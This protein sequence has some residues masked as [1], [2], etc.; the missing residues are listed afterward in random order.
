MANWA[1]VPVT[2][3]GG[4][5]YF[6]VDG[7][8]AA[9]QIAGLNKTLLVGQQLAAGTA[10]AKT[11]TYLA[12]ADAAATAYGAG[13]DLHRMAVAFRKNYPT[14]QLYGLGIADAAGTQKTTTIT[15]T[16]TNSAAGTLY[17]CIGGE[18]LEISIPITQTPTQQTALMKA[19]INAAFGLSM[20]AE[21]DAE[22]LT[23]TARHKGTSGNGIPVVLNRLGSAGGQTSPAGTTYVIAAGVSGATDPDASEC[24]AVMTGRWDYV[25]TSLSSATNLGK[26]K[27]HF[28][29]SW[30]PGVKRFGH[31]FAGLQDDA[32]TLAAFGIARND[33]HLCI[34]GMED[35]PTSDF[36]LGASLCGAVAQSADADRSRP[37]C[38]LELVDVK[39]PPLASLWSATEIETLLWGGIA[40]PDVQDDG[41]VRIGRAVTTYVTNS[42]G[43]ADAAFLDVETLTNLQGFILGYDA[44]LTTKY[45]R[46]K[47]AADGQRFAE[48]LPILTPAALRGEAI[49]YYMEQIADGHCEDL[50][51]FKAGLQTAR[52]STDTSRFD[53]LL[54]PYMVQGARIFAA[55][56]QFVNGSV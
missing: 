18:D 31:C 47:A 41:T 16:G 5:T 43:A 46:H 20:T 56:V 17:L 9:T 36:E 6:R 25:A 21:D 4:R 24:T 29:T 32:A 13:S 44:R 10:T 1:D 38:T 52:N 7:S 49:S 22:V 8:Q 15:L 34:M 2:T 33:P 3:R 48:G 55:L 53:Q 30:T 39:A 50:E 37:T 19:A 14:G 23:L 11:I 45:P 40:T 51:G 54:T 26:F 28:A 42:A 12:D 35:S 27:M